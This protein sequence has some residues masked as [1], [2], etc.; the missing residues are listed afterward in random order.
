MIERIAKAPYN[1]YPDRQAKN[2]KDATFKLVEKGKLVLKDKSQEAV[3][4]DIGPNP[5]AKG[6]LMVYFPEQKILYQSDMVNR[7][8]YPQN[9]STD[10]FIIKIKKLKLS[11]DT[12]VGL[13]GITL[14]KEEVTK[15]L[16]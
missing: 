11:I 14:N 1:L 7:T 3:V 12:M 6:M 2:P 13:H 10:D 9:K 16:K 15:L 8:E 5:H 4:Y